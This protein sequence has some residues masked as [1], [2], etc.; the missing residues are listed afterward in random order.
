MRGWGRPG[1]HSVREERECVR[2]W[3]CFRKVEEEK[4]RRRERWLVLKKSGE[5]LFPS[6]VGWGN[7]APWALGDPFLPQADVTL[8]SRQASSFH[9][10]FH[11]PES[12][13]IS[14]T[15]LLLQ[16]YKWLSRNC[17]WDRVLAAI[18]Y[19]VDIECVSR[20][21]D[22]SRNQHCISL[23][24]WFQGVLWH[25]WSTKWSLFTK[26]FTWMSCKSR[27]ESNEPT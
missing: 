1:E 2:L 21:I 8:S 4:Q 6:R 20:T 10:Y 12:S 14:H 27:D 18:A 19:C 26:F 3:A 24:R 13:L 25:A 9:W 22:R 16:F 23:G 5:A 7:E 11:S 15:T 17:M